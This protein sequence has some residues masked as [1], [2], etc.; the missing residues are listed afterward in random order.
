[1]DPTGT[2]PEWFKQSLAFCRHGTHWW[3]LKSEKGSIWDTRRKTSGREKWPCPAARGVTRDLDQQ[4]EIPLQRSVHI[5]LDATLRG[6]KSAWE[7]Q[8]ECAGIPGEG[9][10]GVGL[11]QL[12]YLTLLQRQSPS[13]HPEALQFR[14]RSASLLYPDCKVHQTLEMTV[15][16]WRGITWFLSPKTHQET[17]LTFGTSD[18]NT[19]L[20]I[21]QWANHSEVSASS[22]GEEGLWATPQRCLQTSLRSWRE[23]CEQF[24][25]SLSH[26]EVIS[27]FQVLYA[28]RE[29]YLKARIPATRALNGCSCAPRVEG[30]PQSP[31]PSTNRVSVPVGHLP[32]LLS[33]L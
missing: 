3:W 4:A 10:P 8:A 14:G 24:H 11:K 22:P 27:G 12:S 28:H 21:I 19:F 13:S 29:P 6:S 2:Q 5:N 23:G 15:P 20:Q 26:L 9:W 32:N 16:Q 1:M 31:G 25:L 7:R 30:P 17:H 18:I 33:S